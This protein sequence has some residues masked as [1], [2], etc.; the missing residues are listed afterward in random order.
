VKPLRSAS[1]AYFAVFLP[2]VGVDGLWGENRK[3]VRDCYIV[4]TSKHQNIKHHQTIKTSNHQ[5]I[6]TSKHQTIKTSKH[7]NIKTSKYNQ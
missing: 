1:T 7:Q 5:T 3:N 2:V 6:K 4:K